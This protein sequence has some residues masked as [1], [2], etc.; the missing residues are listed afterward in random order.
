M[1]HNLSRKQVSLNWLCISFQKFIKR[2][3]RLKNIFFKIIFATIFHHQNHSLFWII[4]FYSVSFCFL[5]RLASIKIRRSFLLYSTLITM[6]EPIN[7]KQHNTWYSS[8]CSHYKEMWR[9]SIFGL[10]I[11]LFAIKMNSDR[12][13]EAG[14]GNATHYRDEKEHMASSILRLLRFCTFRKVPV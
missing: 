10:S 13:E 4:C 2:Y 8:M 9:L 3:I 1:G 6:P 7:S 14:L 11:L 5:L 12:N